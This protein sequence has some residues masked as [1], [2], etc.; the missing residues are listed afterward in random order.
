VAQIRTTGY[1]A[2][3]LPEAGIDADTQTLMALH[4]WGQ[5]ARSFLRKFAAL[6]RH[7]VLVV[8]PQAPHQFYLDMETRKVGFGWMTAFD[9]DRAITNVVAALD[10]ILDKVELEHGATSRRPCVLGFSQGVSIAWRYL[11]HGKRNVAGVV[12]CGG[13]LPPDVERALSIRNPV[14]VLLVHGREDTIVPWAKAQA[15]E[16][17]LREHD[18]PLETHYFAGAHDL[19]AHLTEQLP[20][21]IVGVSR[22]RES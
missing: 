20:Q 22:S 9:R 6:R 10:V 16:S 2:L 4:G 5:N 19:P 7:N 8:A 18:F 13:D 17:Q 12:A 1:Y 3:Q 21:W 14:P 11:I 15:A